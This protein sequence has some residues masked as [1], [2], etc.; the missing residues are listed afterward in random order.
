MC[1]ECMVSVMRRKRTVSPTHVYGGVMSTAGSG[2]WVGLLCLV[3]S[4]R[5]VTLV[6]TH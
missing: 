3:C 5:T 1:V 2:P 6:P 4:G